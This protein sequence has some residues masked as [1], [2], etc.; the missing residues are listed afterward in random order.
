MISNLDSRVSF[1]FFSLWSFLLHCIILHF[2]NTDFSR[3][4]EFTRE[5]FEII[6]WMTM[7]N[8]IESMAREIEQMLSSLSINLFFNCEITLNRIGSEVFHK[9]DIVEISG[10]SREKRTEWVSEWSHN[11]FVANTRIVFTTDRESFDSQIG[12]P[13]IRAEVRILRVNQLTTI[14][15][16]GSVANSDLRERTA[17][18]DLVGPLAVGTY[19]RLAINY[20]NK[21]RRAVTPHGETTKSNGE[22]MHINLM[23]RTKIVALDEGKKTEIIVNRSE[24][25]QAK[26]IVVNIVYFLCKKKKKNEKENRESYRETRRNNA[27]AIQ[28][29]KTS[30]QK[31]RG[32][33]RSSREL[34]DELHSANF[35]DHETKPLEVVA[36]PL[37]FSAAFLIFRFPSRS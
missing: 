9:S 16:R 25:S 27:R 21:R 22:R 24:Y 35:C 2:G 8:L 14:R 37:H 13:R 3:Q 32:Y 19:K 7:N 12:Q 4:Y 31:Y 20:Y 18:E 33:T 5:G 36:L 10:N 11:S 23:P 30:P 1:I 26:Q 29:C 17:R 15:V 6:G 34:R 28:F